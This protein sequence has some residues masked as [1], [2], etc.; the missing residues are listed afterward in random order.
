MLEFEKG[1]IYVVIGNQEAE[2]IQKNI[3]SVNDCY[4]RTYIDSIYPS[5]VETK[6]DIVFIQ[7]TSLTYVAKH[8][9]NQ[10][11]NMGFLSLG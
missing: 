1:T 4:F 10:H 11:L 5:K 2:F 8:I 9:Y 7:S 3:L 6:K